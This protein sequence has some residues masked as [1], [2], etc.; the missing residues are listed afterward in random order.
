MMRSADTLRRFRSA[1]LI[2]GL[3]GVWEVLCLIFRVSDLVLPRP[4]QIA[5]ELVTYFPAL[6]PHALQTLAETMIGFVIGVVVGVLLGIIVG[7]S[8]TAYDVTYPLMVGFASVPK[9][10]VVPIFVLWFGSGFLPAMLTSAAI[11]LFPVMV[12]VSS[13]LA[14]TEPELEDVLKSL[15][16]SRSELLWNVG[17]PR[18]LPFFFASLKVAITLAFVGSVLSETIASNKGIGNAMLVATTSFNIPLVFAAIFL[19]S[20]L[21]VCL[22]E[23]FAFIERRVCGWSFRKDDLAMM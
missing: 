7:V 6:L 15:G 10:A 17:L 8:K 4:S 3:L 11:C 14:T 1:I 2:L 21:G 13:A 18:A 20:A 19:L 12:N 16:A 5:V 23:I 9:I 22:Y